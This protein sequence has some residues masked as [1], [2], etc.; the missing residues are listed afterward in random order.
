MYWVIAGYV[1]ARQPLLGFDSH[2]DGDG[3][4]RCEVRLAPALVRTRLNPQRPIQG[5]RYLEAV[6]APPDLG[7]GY[8]DTGEMP[9]EMVAELRELG[10]L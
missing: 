1:R 4:R 2:V 6:D 3:R 8:A 5:W 10:L 7:L 9:A